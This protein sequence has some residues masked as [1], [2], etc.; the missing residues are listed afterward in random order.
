MLIEGNGGDDC[1]GFPDLANQS[2]MSIKDR[3]PKVCKNMISFLF[4]NSK[5]LEMGI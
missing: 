1:F 5:Q 3:F 4:K 2:K